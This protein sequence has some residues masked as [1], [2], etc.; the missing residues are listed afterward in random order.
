MSEAGVQV[1]HGVND[2]D[3]VFPDVLHDELHNVF[4]DCHAAA[5]L[6]L[7]AAKAV[8]EYGRAP[9]GRAV[10][11][12]ADIEAIL[13]LVL[14]VDDVLAVFHVE[15]GIVVDVDHL[16]VALGFIA[17]PVDILIYLRIG[18]R[19]AGVRCDAKGGVEAVY[20]DGRLAAAFPM[21]GVR[22]QAV[23]A[24]KA[25]RGEDLFPLPRLIS[26]VHADGGRRPVHGRRSDDKQ[27]GVVRIIG[28]R[29]RLY[30]CRRRRSW[31][32][33][34]VQAIVFGD[35][36]KRSEHKQSKQRAKNS[37]HSIYKSSF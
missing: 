22:A 23:A 32:D 30:P 5:G 26:L 37:F 18:Q 1:V 34:G 36:S 2:H 19:A 6:R 4:R 3:A 29:Q 20:A 33:G 14:I 8:Q 28:L 27:L 21:V 24:D 12:E 10:S 16:V 9:A 15:L 11:V 25:G 35:G 31:L 13:V 17:G 7:G